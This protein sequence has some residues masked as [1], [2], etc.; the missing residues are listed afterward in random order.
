MPLPF[1]PALGGMAAGMGRGFLAGFAGRRLGG[2]AS[3]M[4]GMGDDDGT[5]RLDVESGRLAGRFA[6]LGVASVATIKALEGIGGSILQSRE[7]L[8]MWN[9][10]IAGSFAQIQRQQIQLA[11]REGKA[12]APSTKA[13]ADAYMGLQEDIS[14]FQ[15]ARKRFG[16]LIG[17]FSTNIAR[18]ALGPFEGLLTGINKVLDRMEAKAGIGKDSGLD[19]PQ[20]EMRQFFR[21]WSH[22]NWGNP[23]NRR[24]GE[25]M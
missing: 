5:N 2:A 22:G 24:P 1:L 16:N 9:S 10:T 12:L 8:R 3:R 20:A 4:M 6:A 23:I 7:S 15:I 18:K 21:Q 19:G 11:V 14:P 25:K 17:L 13:L